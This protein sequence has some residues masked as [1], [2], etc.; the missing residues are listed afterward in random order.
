MSRSDWLEQRE[1]LSADINYI[2]LLHKYIF[3]YRARKVCFIV[4]V[5][6]EWFIM[7]SDADVGHLQALRHFVTLHSHP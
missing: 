5:A 4:E 7:L 3:F 1:W 2:N 6:K